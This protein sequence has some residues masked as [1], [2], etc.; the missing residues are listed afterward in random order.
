MSFLG[1]LADQISSQ[2]NLTDNTANAANSVIG[3][4]NMQ[5][6]SLGDFS[7]QIKQ[8]AEHRYVE[9]GYLR[10]DPYFTDPKQQEILLQEPNATVLVKKRMFSSIAENYNPDYM[11]GDEKTYYKAMRIL[12]QNK[13]NQI[14]TLEKLSK[15][16]KITSAVGQVDN[17][18]VPY[19]LTLADILNNG[20]FGTDSGATKDSNQF[21]KV[22]DRLRALFAYNQTNKYTTWITDTTS[23]FQSALGQGTGVI[24]I[25]NFVSIN[26]TTTVD[27]HT[28]GN[29]HF[30]ISDPYE[31][32]LI[33]DYD[34]ETAISDATSAY[35]DKTSYQFGLIS[36]ERIIAST[37]AQ[38]NQARSARGAC[39][40]A[41]NSYPSTMQNNGITA[42]IE[43]SGLEIQYTYIG[44][45]TLS[46]IISFASSG[47]GSGVNVPA[48]YLKGSAIAGFNGLD[49][50]GLFGASELKLFQD[51]IVFMFN[52][53]QLMANNLNDMNT[54]MK[55][56]NNVRKKL[57]FNFMGKLIIQPMDTVHIYMG[58]KSRYDNKIM[59]GLQQMFS[60]IGILQNPNNTNTDLEHNMDSLFRPSGGIPLQ[61]EKA[62][63]VGADFPNYLWSLLRS[64]FVTEKE[65]THV[66]AGVVEDASDTW[67]DGRFSVDVSG[68]D[69]TIYFEQGKIN[70]KPQAD[71]FCG[72]WFDPL[73]P[74]VTNFD[75][76]DTLTKSADPVLLPENK[77]LLGDTAALSMVK[78]KLGA[79]PGSAVTNSNYLYDR[80]R[81]PVSGRL[82]KV[83]YAPDGLV[84]KWKEGIGVFTQFGSSNN[85]NDSNLV[86][87]PN[88]FNE[89]FAGLDVMNVL[90]LLI[91]GIPY[92]FTTFYKNTEN[93]NGFAGDPQSQQNAS[94][95]FLN[96][97][98]TNLTRRNTLWGNF[99]PF[100][101]LTLN[102]ATIS[103]AMQ[104]QLSVTNNNPDLDKKLQ[105]LQQLNNQT[106]MVGAI[107]ALSTKGVSGFSNI[108][109]DNNLITLTATIS[110]L[111]ISINK[112]IS[113]LQA[114]NK[115]FASQN[116]IA[117]TY[118]STDGKQNPSDSSSRK[119]L[120]RQ[121]NYLT[122]RMSYDVRA[123]QDK[124]L[125][126]VDDYY[127]VDYDIPAFTA[128][129]TDALKLYNNEYTAVRD[130]IALV[131][132]LLNLEVFC[133]TQ[134]H[135]RV[136]QPQY[137]RM[138]SS[139][140]YR[141]MYLKQTLGIQVF[142]QFL[143]D[144]F[145][146]QLQTLKQNVEVLEDEIRLDCAILGKKISITSDTDSIA[147]INNG[148]GATSGTGGTFQ[149]LSD[150]SGNISDLNSL[151]Q[152][153]NPDSFVTNNGTSTKSILNNVQKY[154]FIAA[155]LNA[156]ISNS[157]GT[158]TASI[159][160]TNPLNNTIAQQLI[161][162][163]NTKSGQQINIRSYISNNGD[164]N[165][166]V[167]TAA[168]ISVDY[169]KVI[170]EITG[171]ITQWQSAIKLLYHTLKNA[172]EYQSLDNN[173]AATG[174][175]LLNPGLFGNSK[176]P[177]VFEHM[178]EDETYDDYGIGSAK[179]FII[180]RSQIRNIKVS[181]KPPPY[182]SV[183]V[184]GVLDTFAPPGAASLDGAFPSGGNGQVTAMAID[185]DLWRNYGFKQAATLDLPFL[186]DPDSQCAPYA[187]MV[188]S[189]N[190]AEVFKATVTISG[191]EYMQPGEVIYLEDRQMLFYV[192]SVQHAIQE[193]GSF[194]TNLELTYGHTAGNYIPTYLDVVGKLIY[195]N[196][197][198][199]TTVVQRQD[200]S[201]PDGPIGVLQLAKTPN[202]ANNASFNTGP[203]TQSINP[204]AIANSTTI[205]NIMYNLSYR[206]NKNGS[207]GN[208][209]QISVEIRLYHDKKTSGA[210]AALNS[211]AQQVLKTLTAGVTG[212]KMSPNGQNNTNAPL[213]AKYV[214]IVPID[215]SDPNERRSPSQQAFQMARHIVG[216]TSTNSGAANN[217]NT[218][219]TSD[220]LRTALFGYV[221]DCW[222]TI[223]PVTLPQS[224]IEPST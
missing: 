197:D 13:C 56:Y 57:Q 20:I 195:K 175:S 53:Q 66:F 136:R 72:S 166:A 96:T 151:I 62:T 82:T 70:F 121:I 59:T 34:I 185:Y 214:N 3:A 11:D 173:G 80:G 212:S 110:N 146:N 16:Q 67:S 55:K 164:P 210:D 83:F 15:I 9:E 125:F 194:T 183:E 18:L 222:A 64:Q 193:G 76:I 145:G 81:D 176:I 189:R 90:S 126:I 91:T 26:T 6:G 54:N 165:S 215:I 87:D 169:F 78:S 36:A 97:L 5:S 21:I 68:R 211:F 177:E 37:Q 116:G 160:N 119:D 155:A 79:R 19:I 30:N 158:N 156:Q 135:I 187:A 123:N 127:D 122:R 157:S 114:Q 39:Q 98:S 216:T 200:S 41:F 220:P 141:M 124:N 102:E 221:I 171:Y 49:D 14:A 172:K 106:M 89:P 206:I 8:P 209:T 167:Q 118:N 153:A 74:F 130:K 46:N 191:N 35:Y 147:F 115:Q 108:L 101:T 178:I 92:N 17:Q 181:E 161:D 196:R 47:G 40:I 186:N 45:G 208:N 32:M 128:T 95:T 117:S 162:R 103:Q 204:I 88:G 85:I 198:I 152:Q 205:N 134:G 84:Y 217:P 71:V 188:L 69:N 149:F 43:A 129:L 140:F 94:H 182:T 111:N 24:E 180:K 132:D 52:K 51:L 1:S 42:I 104:A 29:F 4:Q 31:S 58:S 105:Q 33:T 38:L 199:A 2:Y 107:N 148:S 219:T 137:N 65:G 44:A 77:V 224:N 150:P 203:E 168:T 218:A 201:S 159:S 10:K 60:G 109:S 7:S 190:R 202:D 163:I 22:A 63:Y 23:P 86:G 154:T 120:R 192:A 142:P 184:R 179:R 28:P 48:D 112:S 131:A 144:L 170:Q 27:I 174:N 133:D 139:V 61:A 99:I 50:T 138:P 223:V 213:T 100:K 12:F 73:T 143:N 75:R 113:D 25:T 93:P 207:A